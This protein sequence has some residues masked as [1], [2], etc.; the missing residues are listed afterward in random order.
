MIHKIHLKNYNECS[1]SKSL[2]K[3]AGK[4]ISWKV[5]KSNC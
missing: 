2:V 3:E 4:L 5:S 1:P